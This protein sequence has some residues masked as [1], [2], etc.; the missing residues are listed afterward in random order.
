MY[1]AGRRAAEAEL[2]EAWHQLTAPGAPGI[3][4]VELDE[5]R[6][7]PGGRAHFAGPPRP[8][9]RPVS[10]RRRTRTGGIR[11]KF[12]T[13]REPEPEPGLGPTAEALSGGCEPDDALPI[14]RRLVLP[15]PPE[16]AVS[17]TGGEYGLAWWTADTF[18]AG[19][20]PEFEVLGVDPRA[21][22]T[23]PATGPEPELEAE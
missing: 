8:A 22:E 17:G 1:E 20:D 16:P 9:S 6:G 10:P 14:D 2:A 18:R 3:T 15:D 5:R 13:S 4:H 11:M 21:P 19:A 23:G 7:G 12:R